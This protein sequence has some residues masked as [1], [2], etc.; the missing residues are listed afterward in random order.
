[1]CN[2]FKPHYE[3]HQV[4][5]YGNKETDRFHTVCMDCNVYLLATGAEAE[6][7]EAKVMH[8]AILASLEM[9]E[10]FTKF[11]PRCARY[12]EYLDSLD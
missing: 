8:F 9:L 12:S 6:A 5:V 2:F 11:M 3:Q 1:M 10:P 7:V 4:E